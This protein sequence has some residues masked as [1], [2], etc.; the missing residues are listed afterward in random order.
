MNVQSASGGWLL[1]FQGTAPFRCVTVETKV[2][3]KVCAIVNAAE[4]RYGD[5]P[6]Q[7]KANDEHL[8]RLIGELREMVEEW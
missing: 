2:W 7:Q 4:F 8:D 1:L 5:N 6:S 3:N